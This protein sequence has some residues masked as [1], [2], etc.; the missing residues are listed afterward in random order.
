MARAASTGSGKQAGRQAVSSLADLEKL[1]KAELHLHLRGAIPRD[2]LARLMQ[3]YTVPGALA[4]SPPR[5]VD[6]MRRQPNV[7]RIV[8]ADDPS[9]QIDEL[10]VYD[11][12]EQFLAAYL[13]TG[14]FIRRIEDFVELVE[15]V[16]E[17]LRRQ[18]IVYAE[19]TVSLSEYIQQGIA[20]GDLLT[21]LDS[22]SAGSPCVRWIVDPVRNIGPSA[23]ER[24]VTGVLAAGTESVVGLTLGG[25]EHLHPAGP[26]R[27][28]Y[29]IARE[30]GLRTTVHAGE[31][32]GPESVWDA[33]RILDVDRLGHGVR[34]AEDPDLVRCLAERRVPLEV[35]PT[36]NVRTGVYAV[37]D[38]HPVRELYEAGIPITINTDDPTFFGISL[39]E[40]LA[41]LRQLG[42]TLTEIAELADNAFRVAFDRP[43]AELALCSER[44][45]PWTENLGSMMPD[46]RPSP[47]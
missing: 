9:R 19:I 27:R 24:L 10:F 39:A 28:A 23:A 41:G 7:R 36:S 33:L 31:A 25:A 21:A 16:R 12:F 13:F 6:W 3:R 44:Q 42:F 8:E 38:E 29:E 46:P 30:G 26:F 34:A 2:L 5:Q 18:D 11:T 40:E 43:A 22:R 14:C 15:G 20:L 47:I 4:E 1:P 45:G 35:C 17:G 32:V 37:M